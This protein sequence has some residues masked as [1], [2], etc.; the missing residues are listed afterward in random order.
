M[1]PASM[2][3]QLSDLCGTGMGNSSHLS[4]GHLPSVPGAREHR[5]VRMQKRLTPAAGATAR[6]SSLVPRL[7]LAPGASWRSTIWLDPAP[8]GA[9]SLKGELKNIK[10][11][12]LTFI[13]APSH[14][15]PSVFHMVCATLS[16]S[17]AP[18]LCQPDRD[19]DREVTCVR[20]ERLNDLTI[21]FVQC[22]NPFLLNTKWTLYLVDFFLSSKPP[23]GFS[24]V[25]SP[26]AVL[27]VLT[28]YL[29]LPLGRPYYNTVSKA[30]DF[31]YF[32]KFFFDGRKSWFYVSAFKCLCKTLRFHA[33]SSPHTS[34]K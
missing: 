23:G 9:I 26:S 31:S 28:K 3:S 29:G 4:P 24:A 13:A 19:R 34:R 7:L 33:W 25:F 5:K 17:R 20:K 12:L 22:S 32:K 30:F 2:F 10:P 18:G 1:G 15:P 8:S 16:G 6:L 27:E 14:F 11:P 21:S